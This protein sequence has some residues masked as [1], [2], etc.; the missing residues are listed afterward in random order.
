MA[1]D[2]TGAA[3]QRITQWLQAVYGND[4]VSLTLYGSRA[5]AQGLAAAG[6]AAN[7]HQPRPDADA[8]LLLVLS[9]VTAERLQ[10]GAEALRWWQRQGHRPIAV[11]SRDEARDAADV[12]PI[13]Y[14]D[15]QQHRQV[16]A[17]EDLFANVTRFP[18]E[19]RQQVEHE[20]RTQLLRLRGR[21]PLA[22]DAKALSR[23]MTESA[24]TFLTLFRHALAAL[25]EPLVMDKDAVAAAAARRFGFAPEPWERLL[26]ARRGEA[27]LPKDRKQLQPIFAAYLD[28]IHKV[29]RQLENA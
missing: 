21:Y 18:R 4:L 14:L 26:R 10:A 20:L 12:F 2:K 24:G 23:L 17:G 5:Q 15:L 29:E 1:S 22:G 3:I 6:S 28:A 8:N 27:V 9:E 13:E 11:L 7:G 25:G 19:H 16:L